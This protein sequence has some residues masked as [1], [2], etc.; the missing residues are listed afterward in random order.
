MA[1]PEFLY[2]V[3]ELLLYE[4]DSLLPTV[5]PAAGLRW[6]VWTAGLDVVPDGRLDEGPETV[7]AGLLV[8][9]PVLLMP[10]DAGLPEVPATCEAVA[11]LL[12]AGVVLTAELLLGVRRS[13]LVA[14]PDAAVLF[15]PA[16][17]FLL[18][19]LL[20]PMPLLRDEPLL[21]TLSDPVSCL[22]PYHTSLRWSGLPY[23]GR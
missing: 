10:D 23:S 19:V 21:N 5:A 20:V 3:P 6:F 12:A 4:P 14:V 13:D 22:E 9:V 1:E 18:T 17:L 2:V 15:L 16:V 7:T 8:V 11:F